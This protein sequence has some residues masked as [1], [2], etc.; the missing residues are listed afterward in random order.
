MSP[1]KLFMQK[2]MSESKIQEMGKY[3]SSHKSLP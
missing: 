3:N 2:R 1:Y